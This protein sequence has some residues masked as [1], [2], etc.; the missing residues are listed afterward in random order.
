MM[1]QAPSG[2]EWRR[3]DRKRRRKREE[4]PPK[5][6]V[7]W[8]GGGGPGPCVRE[9]GF[10][11]SK[12]WECCTGV[13]RYSLLFMTEKSVTIN[14]QKER[15]KEKNT[16]EVF[17]SFDNEQVLSQQHLVAFNSLTKFKA[18]GHWVTY[19][20]LEQHKRNVRVGG[21]ESERACLVKISAV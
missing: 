14:M 17:F 16:E 11:D 7:E 21:S 4:G 19:A 3:V 8:A 2:G 20:V 15:M 5:R 18:N 9:E 13:C 10:W 12:R 1:K 6:G